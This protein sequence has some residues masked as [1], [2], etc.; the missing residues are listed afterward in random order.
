M[1]RAP[2]RFT[3]AAKRFFLLGPCQVSSGLSSTVVATRVLSDSFVNERLNRREEPAGRFTRVHDVVS[4]RIVR[5]GLKKNDLFF[6]VHRSSSS[7][8]QRCLT[9]GLHANGTERNSYTCWNSRQAPA[10]NINLA[11]TP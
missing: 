4:Y 2:T 9:L 3:L 7:R 10:G 11:R 8:S 1:A 6:V 5:N